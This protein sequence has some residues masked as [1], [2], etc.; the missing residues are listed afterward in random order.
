MR[1]SLRYNWNPQLQRRPHRPEAQDMATLDSPDAQ[2][3]PT[4]RERSRIRMRVSL[5][6]N[7]NPQLQRRPHRPEAQDMALSRLRHGFESRWGRQT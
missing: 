4:G 6:Y 5:R 3:A 2:G 1:V 7:W